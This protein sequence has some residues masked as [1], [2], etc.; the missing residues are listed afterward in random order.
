MDLAFLTRDDILLL[1]KEE[2][3]NTLLFGLFSVPERKIV[4]RCR[5]P[6]LRLRAQFLRGSNNLYGDHCLAS[7]DKVLRSGPGI[8]NSGPVAHYISSYIPENSWISVRF[9][10]IAPWKRNP[11]SGQNGV[12][13]LRAVFPGAWPLDSTSEEYFALT[14]SY[15]IGPIN[16]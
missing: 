6:F 15:L 7:R 12:R 1:L 3:A 2:E 10:W 9:S 11:L 16:G 13:T 5:L 14:Y 8:G 4:I